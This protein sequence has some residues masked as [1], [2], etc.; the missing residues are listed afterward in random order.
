MRE[1]QYEMDRVWTFFF[2]HLLETSVP[3]QCVLRHPAP[4]LCVW[5]EWGLGGS[6]G[7]EGAGAWAWA[8]GGIWKKGG[9]PVSIHTCLPGKECIA[10]PPGSE[11]RAWRKQKNW[12]YSQSNHFTTCDLM[13]AFFV[14]PV[15]IAACWPESLE[16]WGDGVPPWRACRCPCWGLVLKL[17]WEAGMKGTDA[18]LVGGRDKA[19]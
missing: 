14:S 8:E 18:W 17:G 15:S 1:T 5:L 13:N 4:T 7:L 12:N 10:R 2:V 19:R 9:S 6:W 16:V 11:T 3:R